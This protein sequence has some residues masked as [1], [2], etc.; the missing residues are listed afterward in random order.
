[1]QLIKLNEKLSKQVSKL[2][3]SEPVTHVYNPLEYAQEAVHD[4]LSKY[5]EGPKKVLF[6]GMNP[7]PFGMAQ[8]GVPFGEV[9]AVQDWVKVSGKINQPKNAHSSRP[10][11]G[12]DCHRSEVSGQRIWSL[13]KERFGTAENFFKDHFVWNYCPLLFNE[14]GVSETGR[15]ICRNVTPDKIKADELK[16]LYKICDK[17]LIDLVNLLQPT[18]LVGVGAFAESCFKRVIPERA[19]DVYRILHPS[20]ASPV[21]NRGF[22]P[23]ATKQLIEAGIWS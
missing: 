23:A 5:G 9:A 15:K 4:Y 17:A 8:T 6:L 7:G 14:I 18:Y 13:F 16:P 21:A 22:A 2:K 11:T 12:F 1:M 19:S 20:P 3:F 10:V